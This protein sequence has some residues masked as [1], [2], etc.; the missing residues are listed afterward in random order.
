MKQL[1]LILG[2]S[3]YLFSSDVDKAI[4]VNNQLKLNLRQRWTL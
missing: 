4:K 3:A 2:I 1:M